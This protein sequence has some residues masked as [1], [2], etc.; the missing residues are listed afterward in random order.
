MNMLVDSVKKYFEC[1]FDIVVL[2]N[3]QPII[4]IYTV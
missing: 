4:N 2:K 3:Y 1:Y